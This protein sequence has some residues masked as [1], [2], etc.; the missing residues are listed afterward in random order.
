MANVQLMALTPQSFSG[1]RAFARHMLEGDRLKLTNGLGHVTCIQD[2]AV[3][4]ILFRESCWQVEMIVLLPLAK[5]LRHRHN[6]CDSCDLLLGGASQDIWVGNKNANTSRRGS[7]AANLIRVGK[8][9][10]HEG[11]PASTGSVYLSFQHWDHTPQLIVE[12]WE[13]WQ[14][15]SK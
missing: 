13:S 9:V 4:T 14:Q 5:V 1:S 6:H 7:L 12:D 10:W 3:S 11:S 8:G 2:F 15:D